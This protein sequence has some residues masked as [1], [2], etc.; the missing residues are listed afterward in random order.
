MVGAVLWYFPPQVSRI[1]SAY[2]GCYRPLIPTT[3]DL[4]LSFNTY[5]DD[6]GTLSG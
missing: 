1:K 4:L 2:I 6:V 5:V 3:N